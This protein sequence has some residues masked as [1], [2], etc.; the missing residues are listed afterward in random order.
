MPNEFEQMISCEPFTDHDLYVVWVDEEGA[1]AHPVIA[2]SMWEDPDVGKIAYYCFNDPFE[3]LTRATPG[4][5]NCAG[6]FSRNAM[7]KGCPGVRLD[8]SLKEVRVLSGSLAGQSIP[9]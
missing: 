1:F 7:T 2:I 4:I 9:L 8:E 5:G 3:G 6:V